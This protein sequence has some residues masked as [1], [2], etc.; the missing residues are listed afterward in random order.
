ML[1]LSVAHGQNTIEVQAD[2]NWIAFMTV[3][4]LP[5]DGGG[6]NFGSQ[7][8]LNDAKSTTDPVDN[9]LTLQPNFNTYNASDPF[10]TD[11]VTLEGNKRMIAATFVEPGF[12]FNG[13]DFTFTGNVESYTLDTAYDV[14]YFVRALDTIA[15]GDQLGG[16][17]VFDLPTSGNFSVTV[18]GAELPDSLL[19][20]YGF[21][22]E[23]L[24][25]NPADEAALGSVVLGPSVTSV[26]ELNDTRIPATVFPNP[27]LDVLNIKSE[28][29]VLEYEVS[30]LLGERVLQG[31]GTSRIDVS[32]LPIGTYL[33]TVRFDEGQRVLRFFKQ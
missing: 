19:L 12:S 29:Q 16:A 24:N 17:Y 2:S 30:T 4:N 23:G 15:F 5:A 13:S 8:G 31:Q 33:A 9:T 6:V 7:W 20:Q 11:P 27:V 26:N 21:E 3:F 18:P 14:R 1:A 22:V 10:W 25:A 32:T 28:S